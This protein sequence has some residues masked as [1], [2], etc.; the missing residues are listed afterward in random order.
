VEILATNPETRCR[1]G[2]LFQSSHLGFGR[3]DSGVRHRRSWSGVLFRDSDFTGGLPARR[4]NL[5]IVKKPPEAMPVPEERNPP[6]ASVE[7]GWASLLRSSRSG[8]WAQCPSLPEAGLRLNLVPGDG[9]VIETPRQLHT[10]MQWAGGFVQCTNSPGQVGRT[11]RLDTDD[12]HPSPN[13]RR[14]LPDIDEEQVAE[15][16]VGDSRRLRLGESR[17]HPVFVDLVRGGVSTSSRRTACIA[18]RSNAS[19]YVVRSPTTSRSCCWRRTWSAQELSD[20]Y[21]SRQ[22]SGTSIGSLSLSIVSQATFA[23]KSSG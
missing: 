11:R 22:R 6:P 18:T 9:E 21:I 15:R 20:V 2:N 17:L 10:R 23:T 8:T 13:P 14:V 5:Q 3:T 4:G 16:H 1:D 12:R 19:L 7:P